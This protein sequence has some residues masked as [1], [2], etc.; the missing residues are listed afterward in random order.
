[1]NDL[2]V[3]EFDG[4]QVRT[5]LIDGEPYFVGQDVAKILGYAN[6]KTA[7]QAHCKGVLKRL[8]PLDRRRHPASPR[9]RRG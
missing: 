1:M 3:F 5:V 6:P 8:P 4:S 9:A 2:K 7:V